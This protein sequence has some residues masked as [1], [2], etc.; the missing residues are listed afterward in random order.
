M[1]WVRFIDDF[2]WRPSPSVIIG[3]RVGMVLLVTTPCARLAKAKNRA[4]AAT[5]EEIKDAKGGRSE[6]PAPLSE[7]GGGE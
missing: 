4:V 6:V 7:P 2:D 5:S 1:P 3:Y